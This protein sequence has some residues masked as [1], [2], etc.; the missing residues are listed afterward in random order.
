LGSNNNT[1]READTYYS[2]VINS[3][4]AQALKKF[5]PLLREE[6]IK[7]LRDRAKTTCSGEI[8]SCSIL[9]ESCLFNIKN[10]PCER[11]NLARDP[12]YASIFQDLKNRLAEVVTRVAPSRNLPA[13]K[14][15]DRYLEKFHF[16]S[17]KIV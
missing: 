15:S 3:K 6:D 8:V 4:V 12:A 2:R 5:A 17:F 16:N 14:L 1:D 9:Q 13:G 7:D 10:D 11:V